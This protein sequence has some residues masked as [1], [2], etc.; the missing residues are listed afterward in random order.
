MEE[1]FNKKELS[2][3][4]DK[5]NKKKAQWYEKSIKLL[6]SFLIERKAEVT[7]LMYTK[8]HNLIHLFMN[9]DWII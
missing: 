1:T 2:T 7:R 4:P 3:K 5:N 9:T 6:L 8:F